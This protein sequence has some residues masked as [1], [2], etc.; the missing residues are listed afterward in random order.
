MLQV[1][2]VLHALFVKTYDR[3]YG[4]LLDNCSTDHYITHAMGKK[5]KLSRDNVEL[6]IEG[7]GGVMSNMDTKIYEYPIFDIYE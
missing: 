5:L 3:K 4:A 1:P 6:N 7:I 2:A